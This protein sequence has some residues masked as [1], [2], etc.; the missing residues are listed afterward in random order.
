MQTILKNLMSSAFT[1]AIIAFLFTGCKKNNSEDLTKKASIAISGDPD[2]SGNLNV[3]YNPATRTLSYTITW[4]LIPSTASTTA[5]HFHSHGVT[6]VTIEITGF[7]TGSSG[8]ISGTT[9]QLTK[10][11]ADQLLAG[12]WF[13]YV[14]S[15][16]GEEF[17]VNIKFN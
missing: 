7:S 4:Q 3:N 10:L 15:S 1:I 12:N 5:I 9:R 14:H 16:T 8:T 17:G 6:P 13:I 11:E 2:G